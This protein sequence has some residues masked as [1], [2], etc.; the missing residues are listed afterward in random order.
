[1]FSKHDLPP[2]VYEHHGQFWYVP[3]EGKKVSLARDYGEAM[4]KWASIVQPAEELG[5]VSSLIDWYLVNVAPNKAPRTFEDNKKE[6]EYLKKG[7]GHIPYSQLK[8]HHVATYR[9]TRGKDA[10]VR[11]NREK[12]RAPVTRLH[13]GDGKGHGRF[14]PV[15][16][17]GVRRNA[18]KA[19]ERMIED[20]EYQTVLAKAEPSVKRMMTL[21][22][23]T[24]QRPE[25]LLKAG[26]S[27]VKK[28][29]H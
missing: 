8:P 10:P 6:A 18:E 14:Q 5:T 23:R 21:I 1:M 15:P 27:T 4:R 25:D 19:R 22:Y 24:C 20:H 9:D 29:Q 16:W 13:Q 7:L 17:R 3:R 26:I 11:A 28:I 2:R 12:A